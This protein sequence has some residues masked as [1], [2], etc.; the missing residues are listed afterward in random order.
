MKSFVAVF[1]FFLL[2]FIEIVRTAP[3]DNSALVSK[4]KLMYFLALERLAKFCFEGLINN[5]T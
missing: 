5:E 2:C 1:S 3:S 4:F